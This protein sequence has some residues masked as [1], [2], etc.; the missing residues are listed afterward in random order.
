MAVIHGTSPLLGGPLGRE[1]IDQPLPFDPNF[2]YISS[3]SLFTLEAL[4]VLKYDENEGTSQFKAI[5]A[6]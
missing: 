6:V 3:I 4:A 2:V 1:L 5:G